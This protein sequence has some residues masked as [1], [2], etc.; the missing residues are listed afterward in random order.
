MDVPTLKII[1]GGFGT[2][3]SADARVTA[4]S[5][6]LRL[7]WRFEGGLDAGWGKHYALIRATE[8]AGLT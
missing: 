2:T 8:T 7:A 6:I 4:K 3:N 5:L 1:L